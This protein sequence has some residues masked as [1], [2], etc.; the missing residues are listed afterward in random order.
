MIVGGVGLAVVVA[1]V[2]VLF[3]FRDLATP[4]VEEDI[5]L[6]VITGGGAPGDYGLYVYATTGYES[7][8]ALAGARHDYPAETYLTIQPGGCGTLVRWQ[9]LEQRYTEWD[10]CPDGTLAGWATFHEWFRIDNTDLWACA[11]PMPVQ[12]EPGT[13]WSVE[14]VKPD[15]EEAA[16]AREVI[17]YQ[18]VGDEILI[19]D[20]A[21]V[22]TRH[23]R[24]TSLEYEGTEGSATSDA[25]Y[26]PGTLL[27]VRLVE[28]TTSV[29]DSRIGPVQYTE[30]IE[31]QL[32]SLLPQD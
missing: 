18:V 14:C 17:A 22:E 29:T 32:T 3:G 6:T 7:T 23:V 15:S 24:A 26:L 5:G 27:V 9:P 12:G 1:G 4:V 28:E 13:S 31:L 20:G 10:Y 11:Q 8:D 19:I 21:E 2:A 25:W 30:V 16:A